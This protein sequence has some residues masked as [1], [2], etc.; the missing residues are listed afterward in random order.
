MAAKLNDVVYEHA[1]GS[2]V[3]TPREG[4]SAGIPFELKKVPSLE[5]D[6]GAGSTQVPGFSPAPEAIAGT[7][8]KPTW[9]MDLGALA[10]SLALA[11]HIG[12]G[13]TRIPCD[14]TYTLQRKGKPTITINIEET[15]ITKGLG[16]GK[17]SG[18]TV[19][20]TTIGGNAV[21]IKPTING[22][23][24]DLLNLPAA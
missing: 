18:T 11:V 2:A 7:E 1:D 22:Q 3:V 8:A 23:T 15:L 24:I 9:S 14:V 6:L 5:W 20:T 21:N 12:P 16:G 10:E 19:P 4:D 17:S 13:A